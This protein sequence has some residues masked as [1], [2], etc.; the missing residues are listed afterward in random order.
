MLN[1]EAWGLNDV[2][3]TLLKAANLMDERGQAKHTVEDQQGRLCIQGAVYM[4]LTGNSSQAGKSG[5]DEKCFEALAEKIKKIS[6]NTAYK[7]DGCNNTAHVCSWNNRS[8]CTKEEAVNLMR[9][10]AYT[11]RA[12]ETA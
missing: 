6:D 10:V 4:A 5:L 11:C 7:D 1:N 8:K 9:E 2:G 12:Y 3:R